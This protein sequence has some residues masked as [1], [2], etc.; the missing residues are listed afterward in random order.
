MKEKASPQLLAS[1]QGEQSIC[2]G[3]RA[4]WQLHGSL[5]NALLFA[6]PI[7]ARKP[8]KADTELSDS[9]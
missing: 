1:L 6:I 3:R 7:V 2:H 9:V 4:K 8:D 5:K